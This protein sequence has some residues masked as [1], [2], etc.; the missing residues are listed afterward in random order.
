MKEIDPL[1]L[2]PALDAEYLQ[3]LLRKNTGYGSSIL[4]EVEDHQ[5]DVKDL[6]ERINYSERFCTQ[7]TEDYH[8]KYEWNFRNLF[9]KKVSR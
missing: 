6:K 3:F 7:I 1:P 5:T 4:D 9:H 8:C 2:D